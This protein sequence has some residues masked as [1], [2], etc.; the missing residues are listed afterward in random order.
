MPRRSWSYDG[1]FTKNIT[2]IHNGYG[3]VNKKERNKKERKKTKLGIIFKRD[4]KQ[5]NHVLLSEQI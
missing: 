5:S 4:Y 1:K 2:S 3:F